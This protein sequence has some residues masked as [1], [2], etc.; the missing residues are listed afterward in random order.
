MGPGRNM[1][2]PRSRSRTIARGQEVSRELHPV[3]VE[4]ERTGKSLGERGLAQAGKVLYQQMALGQQTP[5]R[6][7]HRA[8][9]RVQDALHRLDDPGIEGTQ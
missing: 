8:V 1:G 3:E 6:E 5:D 2:S 4:S 9:L 7:L